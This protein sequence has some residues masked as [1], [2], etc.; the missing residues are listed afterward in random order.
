[1][2]AGMSDRAALRWAPRTGPRP[3]SLR[4]A[5]PL[6]LPG[7][8]VVGWV[9][10]T[11][12]LGWF[13]PS[14]LPGPALVLEGLRELVRT[15]ELQ[16][17]LATSAG[18]VALGFV[19][20]AVLGTLLATGVGLSKRLERLLD[21]TL[22]AI[23]SIPALAWV[24]FLLLWLGIGE[25]PKVMLV[26]IGAFFP[27]Y[28]NASSGIRGVDRRLIE[29]GTLH[30]LT[31]LELARR[32]VLPAA[33][34]ALLT[35]LRLGLGQAWLFLVAAELIAASRGLGFLLVDGQNSARADLMVVSIGILALLGKLTDQA[36]R[37]VER[38]LLGWSDGF[39]A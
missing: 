18:R 9:A 27:V 29:V 1:M 8:L 22:Q 37:G 15:G 28:V 13:R 26:A 11:S 5:D 23:R 19:A 32:I 21:P 16:G 25:F 14:Q 35:G 17:H 4:W 34:P 20:G 12:V 24:P 30:G 33:S 36:L 7:L 6:L 31:G 3:L 39:R 38:R 2:S 10:S